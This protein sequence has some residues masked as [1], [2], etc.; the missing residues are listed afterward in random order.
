MS[1]KHPIAMSELAMQTVKQHQKRFASQDAA[2][3]IEERPTEHEGTQMK[4]E[5]YSQR[6]SQASNSNREQIAN[7]AWG[8]D[9]VAGPLG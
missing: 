6:E 5:R 9:S 4:L 2:R 1:S 3:P 8:V 7:D